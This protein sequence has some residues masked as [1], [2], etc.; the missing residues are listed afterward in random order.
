VDCKKE[1]N[2]NQCTC[3]YEPCSRKGLCCQCISYH[4]Q[5]G[6]APA[7][8]FPAHIEKTF[9]RSLRRLASCISR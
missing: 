1:K 8:L 3:T 2:L 5:R 9:D 7:C 4:R 6:E